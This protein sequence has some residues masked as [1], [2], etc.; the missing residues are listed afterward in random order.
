MPTRVFDRCYGAI[1][2][3]TPLAIPEGFVVRA[4]NVELSDSAFL[5][6]RVGTVGASGAGTEPIGDLF[7][8]VDTDIFWQFSKSI[9]LASYRNGIAAGLTDTP[10]GERI[11]CARYNGK[12]FLAYD[13]S[14]NR[15]HLHDGTSVRRVGLEAPAAPTVA[16][17]GAGAYA[18]TLRYYKIQMRIHKNADASQA[19]LATSELGPALSF[20]PSGAGTAARITKPTTIDGATHWTVYAS[21]DGVNYYEITG[22]LAI[23]TTTYD[24]TYAPSVYAGNLAIAPE[25]GLFVPPPS[26][27]F[28][29]SNGE[30]LFMAGAH[31]TTATS[32]Q[33]AVSNRRVWFTRPLGATDRGDDESITQT[34]ASRYW[35]DLDNVDGS[36]IT[37][38]AST[39]DG[40]VYAFTK[41]STWRLSDTGSA[42]APIRAD[43]VGGDVGAYDH[44]LITTADSDNASMVYF[45]AA[46]G[47]YRYSPSTGMQW[48]GED[49]AHP[50][51]NPT[52]DNVAPRYRSMGYDRFRRRIVLAIDDDT[53]S[54]RARVFTPRLARSVDGVIRG[55][56]SVD[57]FSY[58]LNS[59]LNCFMQKDDV[60][61][62]GG[63]DGAS[64]P[65]LFSPS[66]EVTTDSGTAYT[67][68]IETGAFTPGDGSGNF[69]VAEPYIFKPRALS[70][71]LT[72][73]RNRGGSDNVRTDTA[74]TESQGSGDP[75]W[76]R[77]RVEG[78][79]Q[80]DAWC[81]EITASTT[82]PVVNPE[83]RHTDGVDRLVVPFTMQERG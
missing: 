79:G 81:L 8:E 80:A 59:R 69:D 4:E 39:L 13:S 6:P 51:D 12:T 11:A 28:L 72:F 19:R 52:R 56:W 43:R 10:A 15:L 61:Y 17:T 57:I 67:S 34:A 36:E 75:A 45:L 50:R 33:T 58:G 24:D 22:G 47:P 40:A 71:D 41:T 32:T 49:W 82:S 78:L 53:V 44:W 38:L 65:F 70:V 1:E 76:H 74:G 31:E 46:D 7:Y 3:M 60:F 20:T 29:A 63:A 26:A 9:S 48:I 16:N 64:G 68:T 2:T 25:A 66:L 30:R 77:Q 55:G 37:G 27:K 73:T 21:A 62:C 5:V 23:A 35:V 14:V 54:A 83:S 18:A 42:D